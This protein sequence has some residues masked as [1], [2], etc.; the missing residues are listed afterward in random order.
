[1]SNP[2]T[3]L[4]VD[5]ALLRGVDIQTARAIVQAVT[6]ALLKV[7]HPD[8]ATGNRNRFE[9][10]LAVQS[11]LRDNA[12]FVQLLEDFLKPKRDRVSK[13]LEE[14]NM[15]RAIASAH[16]ARADAFILAGQSPYLTVR[17]RG[18]YVVYVIDVTKSSMTFHT[19]PRCFVTLEV[20]ECGAL[21]VAVGGITKQVNRHLI[22]TIAP[23]ENIKQ[24]MHDC[25]S[26]RLD[27][28]RIGRRFSGNRKN[29]FS[30]K[31]E[32]IGSHMISVKDAKPILH[33]LQPGISVGSFLFSGT[34]VAGE[35]YL[36][37]EGRVYQPSG[38]RS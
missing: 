27:S 25:Q 35:D 32:S 15:L 38:A 28:L 12:L 16:E 10:A 24:L 34:S 17:S 21:S 26:D 19:Q 23:G 37:L 36:Y 7:S 9:K 5:P 13:L 29:N 18:P 22:G 3:T 14:H 6:Q 1:M 33:M 30:Q 8:Q 4:G 11:L 2:L 31:S 20:G